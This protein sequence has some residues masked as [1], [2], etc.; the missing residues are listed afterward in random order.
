M[1]TLLLITTL[2]P[3]GVTL[4]YLAAHLLERRFYSRAPRSSVRLVDSPLCR[5]RS[6]HFGGASYA[7]EG[8]ENHPGP[9]HA[10]NYEIFWTQEP[11]P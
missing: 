3:V 11:K 10:L 5:S 4:V 1:I 6:P 2:V 9:H 7:C 8:H